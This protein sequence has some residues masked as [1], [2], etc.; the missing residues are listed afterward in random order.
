MA[1]KEQFVIAKKYNTFS[2]ALM[3]VGVLSIIILFITN[4]LQSDVHE[5]ARFWASLLQKSVYF[6]LVVNA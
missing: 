4:G 6:L 2:L 5:Q 3:A 1:I